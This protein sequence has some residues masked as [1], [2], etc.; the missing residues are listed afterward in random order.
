MFLNCR[1]EQKEGAKPSLMTYEQFA[2][3]A[4]ASWYV[5]SSMKVSKREFES[6]RFRTMLQRSNRGSDITCLSVHQLVKSVRAE[7][8][9]YLI[10]LKEIIT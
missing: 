10:F 4:Q 2:L 8:E 1:D 3:S 7:F 5:Y 6:Q 9:V